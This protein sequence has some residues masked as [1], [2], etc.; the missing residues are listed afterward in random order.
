MKRFRLVWKGD[1][2]DGFAMGIILT[3]A[4]RMLWDLTGWSIV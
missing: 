2:E 4:L 1:Y 3:T